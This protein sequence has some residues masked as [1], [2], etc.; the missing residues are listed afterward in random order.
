FYGGQHV[1]LELRIVAMALGIP[2]HQRK[3]CHKVLQV[4]DDKSRHPVERVEFA[5]LEERLARTNLREIAGGLAARGLQQVADL[6]VH[7]DLGTRGAKD[8]KADEI[9]P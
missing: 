3:L 7:F 1:A 9:G 6:P 2:K 4:V 5:R 8:D